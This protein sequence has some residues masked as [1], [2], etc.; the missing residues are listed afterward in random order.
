MKIRGIKKTPE[1]SILVDLD[2]LHLFIRNKT[3]IWK[4]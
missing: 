4:L 2:K 3:V 1:Y